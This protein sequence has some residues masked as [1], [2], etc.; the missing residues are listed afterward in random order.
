MFEGIADVRD[1][2]AKGT[3]VVNDASEL[4]AHLRQGAEDARAQAL[5][6]PQSKRVYMIASRIEQGQE[7]AVWLHEVFHK[8]GKD[9]L[10]EVLPRLHQAA[11]RW[12]SR[13]ANSVERQIYE[14]AHARA[15]ADGNYEAEFL[16]Y[17]IEE[18]VN[19]GVRPNL[20]SN[21]TSAGYW[22]AR[23]R[24]AFSQVIRAAP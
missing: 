21:I 12:A 3:T 17:A 9:L 18:A 5:Y 15:L 10:G 22:L 6:D 14:A 24:E 13:P 8:N 23:V 4:P 20:N 2:L 7:K 19:R 16:A 11:Q 1:R